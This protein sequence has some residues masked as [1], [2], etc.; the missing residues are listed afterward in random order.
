MRHIAFKI[1][2]AKP[3]A[4][5]IEMNLFAQ[6]ALRTDA[7]AVA[8]KQ[9]SDHEFRADRQ[10]AGLTIIR[11]QLHPDALKPDDLSILRSK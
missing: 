11:L 5:Q 10:P 3:S 9:H 8:D 2:S 1:E 4:S 6:P 7:E